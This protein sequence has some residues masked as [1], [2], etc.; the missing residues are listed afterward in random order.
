MGNPNDNSG[1][2]NLNRQEQAQPI[3]QSGGMIHE[4]EKRSSYAKNLQ[5][6]GRLQ[7]E[8]K[9][10]KSASK[11]K[12]RRVLEKEYFGEGTVNIEDQIGR[13]K[14]L[15]NAIMDRSLDSLLSQEVVSTDSK[16]MSD[17]KQS[18]QQ[19]NK[20]L[21]SH[22]EITGDKGAV[23]AQIEK[24]EQ[25][26]FE[27]VTACRYY[28]EHKNPYFEDGI[29]RK[30]AVAGAYEMLSEEM[31]Y[32]PKL[33]E[34]ALQ[35][36]LG[37]V[38]TKVATADLIE[39]AYYENVAEEN[40]KL[41]KQGDG[42]K[43]KDPIQT[44]TLSD[45]A[46]AITADPKDALV[47]RG[48]KLRVVKGGI[49]DEQS[50]LK[51]GDNKKMVEH[52]ID[53]ALKEMG[54]TQKWTE[55]NNGAQI[56]ALKLRLY[57]NLGVNAFDEKSG[58]LSMDNFRKTLEMIAHLKSD[59]D[60][61][62]SEKSQVSDVE[63]SM[64][65]VVD[66]TLSVPGKDMLASDATVKKLR[67]MLN[68]AKK[69]GLKLPS[70]SDK[71]LKKFTLQ[72]FHELRDQ[73][74]HELVKMTQSVKI[75]SCGD[76]IDVERL[77][78]D[79]KLMN[80]LMALQIAR[81]TSQSME[82]ATA[83]EYQLHNLMES[84]AFDY[85]E[86]LELEP[87][88]LGTRV[89]ELSEGGSGDLM[90]LAMTKL[91]THKSW[92]DNTKR[93]L[94]GVNTLSEVCDLLSKIQEYQEI[95]L[96]EGIS[97]PTLFN[98]WKK[99]VD[100]AKQYKDTAAKLQ[101]IVDNKDLMKDMGYVA[102]ELEGTRFAVGFQ[103]LEAVSK[104][105]NVFVDSTAKILR[106]AEKRASI[107]E[108]KYEFKNETKERLGIGKEPEAVKVEAKEEVLK[109]F[110]GA[111]KNIIEVLLQNKNASALIKE[112]GDDNAQNLSK[113]YNALNSLKL[114]DAWADVY[115]GDIKLT[116]SARD[117][118][119]L[120]VKTGDQNITLPYKAEYIMSTM[121]IDMSKNLDKYGAKIV[122]NALGET[123]E[124]TG[125]RDANVDEARNLYTNIIEKK[126]GVN[127]S[128]FANFATTT[129]ATLADACLSDALDEEMM[130]QITESEAM[131]QL[132]E[133]MHNEQEMLELMQHYEDKKKAEIEKEQTVVFKEYKVEEKLEEEQ[134]TKEE[135]TVIEFLAGMFSRTDSWVPDLEKLSPGEQ[136]KRYLH[137]NADK[138]VFIIKNKNIIDQTFD[139]LKIPG[140][141]S[142]I[143]AV[144]E[145]LKSLPMAEQLAKISDE[146]ATSLLKAVL[147][148][149]DE[150][151]GLS[152]A[153]IDELL[154]K[155]LEELRTQVVEELAEQKEGLKEQ[156][157][158]KEKTT[159]DKIKDMI[160][161]EEQAKRDLAKAKGNPK[162]EEAAKKKLAASTQ[163]LAMGKK[164]FGATA[165]KY[166]LLQQKEE[167][168]LD[169]T[170][171][172]MQ[173]QI[174][175]QTTDI[176]DMVQTQIKTSV[177]GLFGGKQSDK[178]LSMLT[179]QQALEKNAK[180]AEGQGKF[181]RLVLEGY[182]ENASQM[183]KRAMVASAI[184]FAKPMSEVKD[185]ANHKEE[186]KEA[187]QKR[188]QGAFLGGFLKGAGPLMHKLLQ[189][190][191]TEGMDES[192]KSAIS[193]TKS[194]LAPIPKDL[195]QARLESVVKKS[196][197]MITKIEIERS[198][199]AASIG[200]AFLC[201]IHGP[202]Y[203]EGGKE[204][205]IK[206]L[207]PDAANHLAR[208]KNFM[209]ECASKTDKG[210]RKT[211][212]TTLESIERE[213][214][215]RIEA[216]NVKKGQV[217]N[218]KANKVE[219]MKLID[220]IDPE[221]GIMVVEKAEGETVDHYIAE[222]RAQ[223]DFM[224]K[225]L[226][227][228]QSFDNGISISHKI[229]KM[230]EE[231]LV[232]QHHVAELAK[233]WFIEGVYEGG[234]FHGDLHAGNIMVSHDKATAIDFGNATKVEKYQQTHVLHLVCAAEAQSVEGF[235]E[236]FKPLLSEESKSLY[237]SKAAMFEEMLSEVLFKKGDPGMRIAVIL[238]EA[239]KMGLEIPAALQSFSACE[240]R[241][242]NTLDDMNALISLS[243]DALDQAYETDNDGKTALDPIVK[244]KSA[245]HQNVT[246]RKD[247]KQNVTPLDELVKTALHKK[248]K[249]DR[250]NFEHSI[251]I[252]T[253]PL[254][255]GKITDVH[256]ISTHM[257][258]TMNV[259][260]LADAEKDLPIEYVK[261]MIT[262]NLNNIK[263]DLNAL[264][265]PEEKITEYMKPYYDALEKDTVDTAWFREELP[266]LR[267]KHFTDDIDHYIVKMDEYEVL[268]K[269]DNSSE[270]Q[271]K[272]AMEELVAAGKKL[273]L[274]Q[275]SSLMDKLRED[276]LM[277]GNVAQRL[278][279]MMM[280]GVL[281]EPEIN[282]KHP[283]LKQSYDLIRERQKNGEKI[284]ED[285]ETVQ[286]FL[287]AFEAATVTRAHFMQD[288]VNSNQ[289][290]Y[291]RDFFDV[292][293]EV[294]MDRK[295]KTCFS[296]LGLTGIY[297]YIIKTNKRPN[298][299]KLKEKDD[300]A[301][302]VLG[303]VTEEVED[304]IKEH[305]SWMNLLTAKL[306][307]FATVIDLP[308]E[309]PVAKE[310]KQLTKKQQSMADDAATK[311]MVLA[312]VKEL[313]EKGIPLEM[314]NRQTLLDEF[315]AY[316]RDRKG[317]HIYRIVA[318]L[319]GFYKKMVSD[320]VSRGEDDA[321]VKDNFYD[322]W[323]EQ[324]NGLIDK[325]FAHDQRIEEPKKAEY[326][327]KAPTL[328]KV[329]KA[330]GLDG[331]SVKKS[332][333]A[334]DLN[335][336]SNPDF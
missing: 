294:I 213:L 225:T 161:K 281:S 122:K 15:R 31:S 52:L 124:K 167:A 86:D 293:G 185:G 277:T 165:V 287:E 54:K 180:G 20:L 138:L 25:A 173:E 151:E 254:T 276:L 234:F 273:Y 135:S 207:R 94:N 243:K 63:R 64:A 329:K 285:D 168:G 93:S 91:A 298:T 59:V 162:E 217:Y 334:E 164:M 160:A 110:K 119:D 195:V 21:N 156:K 117:N 133:S 326:Y 6:Q 36:K 147:G 316:E 179:L 274:F 141:E 200:Q 18:V 215:L 335:K 148:N 260:D 283:T 265:I 230:R 12:E 40:K 49:L 34:K 324:L 235:M 149:D 1:M 218:D 85:C 71:E 336:R 8:Q 291:G 10:G 140:A 280:D 216:E 11:Q 175:Q 82:G 145:Q 232:R 154:D 112:N 137:D 118:G 303:D 300:Y 194:K 228:G 114:G 48:G 39:D 121:Q 92:K 295:T 109:K 301:R 102:K 251:S 115:F 328:E 221:S 28:C 7:E 120:T 330:K 210:M 88:Y 123:F 212:E 220:I 113:L 206:M 87:A 229:M 307:D 107:Y 314:P 203:G 153:A 239:Q 159:L 19:C 181:F 30:N 61:V 190:L 186:D 9:S 47:F 312:N 105:K 313:L 27:A 172:E 208:E 146:T 74:F 267:H 42:A 79:E 310:G 233:K 292:A 163:A 2:L 263:D 55:E 227:N 271:K 166:T 246:E 80:N 201:K 116:L 204:V 236:H 278:F 139:K 317:E 299:G 240:I 327:E 155:T 5:E 250:A 197:K 238:A 98:F 304:E 13:D 56:A 311:A 128:K 192:L 99:G 222:Q 4:E 178:P 68:S 196:H 152:Q 272:Q 331:A 170:F 29:R 241:L 224:I 184:R 306:L 255:M 46:K 44:L 65:M 50:K 244:L 32:L 101:S 253:E 252:G 248:G 191:P 261:S 199:G 182:F 202:N 257:V 17:V 209:L 193:D 268:R 100:V 84:A 75:L 249:S 158:K 247:G 69:S 78:R 60:Y 130:K 134:W 125:K 106:S 231:L 53:V 111:T 126:T 266:K 270:E 289:K 127:A 256:M 143:G 332:K 226:R 176:V 245:I 77:M 177:N 188:Q 259:L 81:L 37:K 219:S 108:D 57:Q 309:A 22:I 305:D 264:Q 3:N 89:N 315:S 319:V 66:K 132:N 320:L 72:N 302:S 45:Y 95:A 131:M 262:G 279:G 150:V 214:D 38:G 189:G 16:E 187:A 14:L 198:L 83:A 237:D 297:R 288:V 62:L 242:K 144:K 43:Q 269:D 325:A 282:E 90:T 73:S 284:P 104:K 333:E 322:R 33:K 174:E 129:L 171:A 318:P 23:L 24:L 223:L 136:L 169:E 323:D 275:D 142:A 103:R 51:T 321:I 76:K 290:R 67:S 211:Y 41:E 58:V 183:D 296:K 96:H 258:S 26:Y 157:E 97:K 205:V 308:D 35:G 70:I 286:A